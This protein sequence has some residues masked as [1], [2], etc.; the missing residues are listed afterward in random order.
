[1]S[2]TRF[3]VALDYDKD[4]TPL[5]VV[6]AKGQGALA[7]RM[8]EAAKQEGI[9]IMQNVPLAAALFEQGTENAYI[10]RD[11]LGAVAEVLR[12]VQNLSNH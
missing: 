9:P 4:K 2:K 1:M 11:L 12:W 10:P 8:I 6:L 3:A 7:E 5:P